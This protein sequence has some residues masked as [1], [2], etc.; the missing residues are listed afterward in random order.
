V[1]KIEKVFPPTFTQSCFLDINC[2]SESMRLHELQL[3]LQYKFLTVSRERFSHKSFLVVDV[4]ILGHDFSFFG[5]DRRLCSI[6]SQRYS[7]Y[8]IL[9]FQW[10]KTEY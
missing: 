8:L 3:F 6:A 10:P 7:T 9:P 1:V 5:S 4:D 2:F